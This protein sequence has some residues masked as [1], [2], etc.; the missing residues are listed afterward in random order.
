[1]KSIPNPFRALRLAQE[2][3][4]GRNITF[5][6]IANA[7]GVPRATISQ[8]ERRALSRSVCVFLYLL[9][10]YDLKIT[11]QAGNE[12]FTNEKEKDHE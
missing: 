3:A 6:E 12:Y 1:M 10:Y 5:Q 7:V 2:Q 11:D 9:R 8:I 4:Q